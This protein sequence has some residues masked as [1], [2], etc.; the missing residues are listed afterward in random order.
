MEKKRGKEKPSLRLTGRDVELL[1]WIN[2]IGFV[3]VH[4]V[5]L[6]MKVVRTTAYTR[7]SKLVSHGYLLHRRI[8]QGKPGVY[9]VTRLGAQISSSPLS[10]MKEIPLNSYHH[11]LKVISLS[12]ALLAQTQGRRFVPEREL[13]YERGLEEPGS[14]GHLPD[15]VLIEADGRKIA[16]ELELT[17]KGKRRLTKIFQHH[18]RMLPFH[19][20]EL[21]YFCDKQIVQ[22]LLEPMIVDRGLGAYVH[23]K[24][25]KSVCVN[26]GVGAL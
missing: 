18:S 21:W 2:S 11:D 7:L 15:G 5:S 10:P 23:I 4:H 9:S 26:E 16:I 22:R 12:L 3:E 20:D 25:L 14:R 1:C 6:W 8:F 24:D 13:R 17:P 19:F